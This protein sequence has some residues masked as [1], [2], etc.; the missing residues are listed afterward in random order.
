MKRFFTIA[1]VATL[2]LSGSAFAGA[3]LVVPNDAEDL[4]TPSNNRFPLLV[5]GGMR[6]Q[7]VFDASQFDSFGGPRLITQIAFRPDKEFGGK[8]SVDLSDFEVRLSSTPRGP[9]GLDDTF[10]NNI[11]GDEL[12]V[13]DGPINLSRADTP[14]PGNTRAFDVVIDLQTPFSYDPTTKLNLLL[15]I[16]NRERGNNNIGLA[17]DARFES[18]SVSRVFSAEGL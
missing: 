2:G 17:F 5:N 4:D 7:Q 3:L 11:G 13:Y 15:D 1:A 12:L 16:T 18:D 10:A 14:G 8:F 6:Y 9:D